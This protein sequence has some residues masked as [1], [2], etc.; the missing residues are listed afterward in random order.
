MLNKLQSNAFLDVSIDDT[1]V[2]A[3]EESSDVDHKLV[4]FTKNCNGRLVTNDFN[5]GKVAQLREVD[6]ININDMANSLRAIVLPGEPMQIKLVKAGEE[7]TQ[8]I[9]Y[10]EDGTMVVVEGG[11]DKIGQMVQIT[12]TS[13]L[14]TSAGKMV[15]GKFDK[16][17]P[18]NNE[19]RANKKNH[20]VVRKN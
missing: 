2:P 20:E 16:A 7:E 17:L 4:A 13:S 12:V 9:G 14:Q 5:L 3:G 15:F 8:G 18:R 11:R 10:L 1:L 19:P 6:V